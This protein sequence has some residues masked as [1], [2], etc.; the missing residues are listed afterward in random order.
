MDPWEKSGPKNG[1]MTPAPINITTGGAVKTDGA[2]IFEELQVQFLNGSTV[3]ELK[4]LAKK[5]GITGYS[6][7][8][9]DDL[10]AVLS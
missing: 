1:E 3:A 6:K 10:L 9:R 7:M 8:K 5:R 4:Q 2:P